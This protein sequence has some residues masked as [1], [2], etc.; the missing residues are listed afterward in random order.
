MPQ[1]RFC[2]TELGDIVLDL[3][4]SPLANAYILPEN[5]MR[6]EVYYPLRLWLCHSCGL[7]QLEEFVAPANIFSDYDYFSSY[8]ESWLAHSKQYAE[9]MIVERDLS[10]R[11]QVIE[12]AS[13]DGYLLQYFVQSG[14]PVLGVEPAFN[15]AEVAR[16]RGIPTES[17][18][19]G[20][21][22]AR[23]LR[24][25]GD[26]AD[27]LI[28]NNVLAHVPDI[29]DFV[30]G[31]SCILK[32]D[33]LLT[34]EFPHLLKLVEGRQFDTIYHEHFS[35]FSLAAVS[36]ILEA[37]GLRIAKTEEL[38]VHGGSLRLFVRH[39]GKGDGE[40]D[41]VTGD[42]LRREASALLAEPGGYV[43]LAEDAKAIK[44]GLLE[45]LVEAR[46]EGE[47][48]A[49]YGAAAKGNTLLNYA[50]VKQDLVS[51]VA[52]R[53]PAKQGKL[54][55]GSR[56]PIVSPERLLEEK[57]ERVLILPWNLREEIIRQLDV[58]YSW[59]GEFV[60]AI[61]RLSFGKEVL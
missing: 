23:R 59:G 40:A 38:P 17:V 26:F 6:G 45:F 52:D 36:R 28:G 37:H 7:A 24:D 27:L 46:R 44:L 19:F 51:M 4:T 3:G 29:N 25:A 10:A 53:N 49:A 13:N 30:A 61:P 2:Q 20:L 32:P 39:A 34:L 42:I 55:P 54:L 56:I 16:S 60:T 41:P 1:C 31:L 47:R 22:A 11:S 9:R 58:V 33:G 12:I 5:T 15:V 8:S 50:G 14:I 21:Q 18:F 43:G 48:V 35:Y 57:P